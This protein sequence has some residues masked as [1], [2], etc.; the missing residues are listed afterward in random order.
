MPQ[1]DFGVVMEEIVK[2][3]DMIFES[4]SFSFIHLLEEVFMGAGYT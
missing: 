3:V 4:S 2:K 1:Y